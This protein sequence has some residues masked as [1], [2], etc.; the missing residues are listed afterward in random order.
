MNMHDY[1]NYVTSDQLN[2]S[3]L[4]II[5]QHLKISMEEIARELLSQPRTGQCDLCGCILGIVIPM[6][7]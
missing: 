4:Y 1:K 7:L 6:K 2:S 3:G 5:R